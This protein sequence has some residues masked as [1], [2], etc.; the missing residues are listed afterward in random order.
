MCSQASSA[1]RVTAAGNARR[2]SHRRAASARLGFASREPRRRV[3]SDR[4]SR[5]SRVRDRG[6]RRA[7]RGYVVAAVADQN[8]HAARVW[9]A[10]SRCSRPSISASYS[11]VW[12]GGDSVCS[13]ASSAGVSAAVSMP[14]VERVADAVVEFDHQELVFRM[15]PRANASVAATTSPILWRMLPESSMTSAM[16]T[17]VSSLL[18]AATSWRRPSS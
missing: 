4:S 2:R 6:P 7:L 16:L 1:D 14:S 10:E 9:S 12:P 13:V 18:N 17:G 15:A 8:Q 11:A 5:S 3:R